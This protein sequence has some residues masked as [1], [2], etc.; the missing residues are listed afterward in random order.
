MDRQYPGNP[1]PLLF[2]HFEAAWRPGDITAG[3]SAATC[4]TKKRWSTIPLV[5][6]GKAFCPT[7]LDPRQFPDEPTSPQFCD[8][9]NESDLE[10]TDGALIFNDSSFIDRGLYRW[11]NALGAAD[12]A[13]TSNYIDYGVRPSTAP[14]FFSFIPPQSSSSEGTVFNYETRYVPNG[15]IP[16]CSYIDPVNHN[17]LTTTSPNCVTSDAG[18]CTDQD[19]LP[20]P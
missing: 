14:P 4:L 19:C 1:D 16:L 10:Q 6:F 20:A 18:T 15:L 13:T 7:L 9:R 2:F 8:G 12:N 5:P 11:T 3:L 17:Y